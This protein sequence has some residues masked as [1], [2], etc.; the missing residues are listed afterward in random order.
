MKLFSSPIKFLFAVAIMTMCMFSCQDTSAQTLG[1]GS[2]TAYGSGASPAV[3]LN[4]A[5][6]VFFKGEIKGTGPVTIQVS[7]LSNAALDSLTGTMTLYASLDGTNYFIPQTW[8]SSAPTGAIGPRDSTTYTYF[9]QPT[10]K[11][12]P[13]TLTFTSATTPQHV[14]VFTRTFSIP[15]NNYRYY[16]IRVTQTADAGSNTA[17]ATTQTDYSPGGI[18]TKTWSAT[19]WCRRV[20]GYQ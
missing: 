11:T 10:I 9:N 17:T 5:D 8:A 1:T 15:M 16:M 3:T 18:P 4:T 7:A 19:F 6:T 14:N 13:A 12:P 20:S 2:L